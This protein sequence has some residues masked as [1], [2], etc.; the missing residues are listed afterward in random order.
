MKVCGFGFVRNA[1]KYSFPVVESVKS[2]L[3]VCDKFIISVGESED[4]TL[5][6]VQTIYSDKLK[7]IHSVWDDRLRKGG[8]VLAIETN[9][10]FD[11]IPEEYDWVFYMQADEIVHEKFLGTIREAMEKY[12]DQPEVEGFLFKYLH[13]FGSFRYVAD[14]RSWYRREV[15]VIRND[16]NIRSF[17]DAQ[18]FRKNG[19]QLRVRALDVF[20]YHYGWVKHPKIMRDKALNNRRYWHPDEDIESGTYKQF[21]KEQF[22]FTKVDSI[23]EFDGDHPAVIKGLIKKMNWDIKLDI[24]KKQFDLRNKLL[25][26]IEKQTGK[27]LF[28]Y[29]NYKLIE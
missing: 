12:V 6:L 25:H 13:F 1:V 16:K 18:G 14:S 27:R 10:V 15:R 17:R 20:I 23:R 3:P 26:W 24:H 8:E 22:D 5:D 9:K 28:E 21:H 2:I 29:K 7:I 19:K 4:N 11:A